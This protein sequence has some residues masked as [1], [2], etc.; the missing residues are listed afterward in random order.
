[1]A[2]AAALLFTPLTANEMLERGLR[3]LGVGM[4]AQARRLATTN[5][6]D[7][8]S[9]FGSRPTVIADLWNRLHTTATGVPLLPGKHF[10][11]DFLVA[12][13]WLRIYPTEK[14]RKISLHIG[15]KT[16]RKWSWLYAKKIAAL[17]EELIQWPADWGERIFTVSV[18][19]VHF[20]IEEPLHPTYKRDKQYF[21]HKFGRAGLDY[22]IAISIFESKVVWINGPFKAGKHDV[23]IFKE[24]GLMQLIPQGK[25]VIADRGYCGAAEVVSYRNDLDTEEVKE[26][27]RRALSRHE[28]FNNR[29]HTFKSLQELFRH[30]HEKHGIAFDT[31]VVICQ[32]ELLL[33]ASPLFDV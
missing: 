12:L 31:V 23:R 13:H 6:K 25:R 10:P 21:S 8:E 4:E 11:S 16:G 32:L 29:I 28:N 33:N 17:K 1:M 19:G 27:K 22:E 3:V 15:E 30:S 26:F 5:E 14:G 7:F 24:D 2:A 18:D 20:R 9:H